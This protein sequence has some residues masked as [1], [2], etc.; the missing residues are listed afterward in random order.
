MNIPNPIPA[1]DLKIL[2][3]ILWKFSL[4]KTKEGVFY[5]LIFCI[6]IPQVTY[7][8]TRE[9]MKELIALNFYQYPP[10]IQTLKRIMRPCRFKRKATYALEA[11][12]EFDFI[13]EALT[14]T[15]TSWEEK[16]EHLVK[17]VKGLGM[18]TASH[19]LRNLGNSDFAIIDV[20]VLKFL[21]VPGPRS[22]KEY[23]VIEGLFQDKAEQYGVAPAELD[24]YVWKVYSDTPWSEFFF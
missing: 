6:A 12:K 18:K 5:D 15:Q 13:Y 24:A 1:E 16:R 21:G 2:K 22:N 23:L 4:Q 17:N 10:T 8:K 3:G 19:L 9:V 7:I 11:W 14:N 20:H